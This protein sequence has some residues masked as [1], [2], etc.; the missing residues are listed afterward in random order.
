VDNLKGAK[1]TSNNEKCARQIEAA[2]L[3][4]EARLRW[5]LVHNAGARRDG[6]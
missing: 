3:A 4:A 5:Q 6:W 1:K 2:Q